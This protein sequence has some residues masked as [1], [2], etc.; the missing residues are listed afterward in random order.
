MRPGAGQ[1]DIGMPRRCFVACGRKPCIKGRVKN[2]PRHAFPLLR[3]VAGRSFVF[4]TAVAVALSARAASIDSLFHSPVLTEAA[5][6]Q[7]VLVLPDDSFLAHYNFGRL[8][9][10]DIGPLVKFKADGTLD[11]GFTMSGRYFHVLAVAPTSNGRLY[12]SAREINKVGS[13]Y[14][15]LRLNPDGSLDSSFNA[16]SGANGAIF[17]ITVQLDN[18]VLVGGTFTTFNGEDRPYLVRLTPDGSVENSFAK[19]SLDNFSGSGIYSN[20]I[21]Q[22]D[23][24]IVF[25]GQFVVVNGEDR[26]DVARLN[27][28]GTLDASFVPSGYSVAS[29]P[30]TIALQPDGKILIG[31]RFIVNGIFGTTRGPLMRLNAD[32]SL[33]QLFVVQTGASNQPTIQSIKLL[34]DGDIIGVGTRFFRFTAAGNIVAGY[35]DKNFSPSARDV[36]VQSDGKIL[37]AGMTTINNVAT[38]G[39]VRYNADG[40]GGT[41][42]SGQ[43]QREI[44]PRELA[45]RADGK[46]WLNGITFFDHIDGVARQGLARLKANGE[47]DSFDPQSLNVGAS[48]FALH[49]NDKILLRQSQGTIIRLNPDDTLDGSLPPSS[50]GFPEFVP[51]PQEQYIALNNFSAQAVLDDNVIKRLLPNGAFDQSFQFGVAFSQ[52]AATHTPPASRFWA[53]DNRPLAF[54]EDGRFLARYFDATGNYHLK[55]FN[56][57]GSLDPDFQG[58]DV[59]TL[60]QTVEQQNVSFN[61]NS[62]GIYDVTLAPGTPL[63]DAVLLPDGKIIVVGMFDHYNGAAAPAIVRLQSNGAIDATFRAGAGAQWTF[64]PVDATHI[65]RIDAI[66]RL[67]D[68]R[69]LIAGNF[70]AYDGAAAPGIARLHADGSRDH[71]FSSPVALADTYSTYPTY[72]FFPFFTPDFPASQL[73]TQ[74]DGSILLSG[75]YSQTGSDVVQSLFRLT[76]LTTTTPL[77]ISTRMR[78]ETG[79]NVLIGGFI[80]T[81]NAP[82]KVIVRAIGPTL[83]AAGVPRALANPTLELRGAGG[84][85]LAS[86][87]DWRAGQQI[88]IQNSGLAP[89]N[90]YESAIIT[91]LAPGQY[92]AIVAGKGGTTGAGLLEIYDLSPASD[93]ELANISTRGFV[94]TGNDVMIGGF[95]LG[96]SAGATRVLIRATGPSLTALGISGALQDPMLDLFDEN[97]AKLLTN[98]NWKDM[99]RDQI[100]A[101]GIPPS[102]DA[103]SAIVAHL[104]AGNYTAIVSGK[105]N[106]TGVALVE[107]YNVK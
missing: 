81:G 83:T 7:R 85:L 24:K 101:T 63:S 50:P 43:F 90:D 73:V 80:I 86:N 100:E 12:V 11:S 106:T 59:P 91:T 66:E 16:G 57:D 76:R 31:A 3:R 107:V 45:V 35:Q 27:S 77:N 23:G 26:L 75:N 36:D 30:R 14:R 60:T 56:S 8:G 4:I 21:V 40:T 52:V 37:V 18:N 51:A 61:N 105:S 28:N 68:G 46:I 15:L 97:G 34:A 64:T 98:D 39:L 93:S 65:P 6:P 49:P 54:Y 62:P 9:G 44:F 41:S 2:S 88:E 58:G 67:A 87:D 78:V 47:V 19:I 22:P 82:K 92:T 84:V 103:D 70:E 5:P 20:I 29:L 38:N 69:F 95:I 53:G 55:R 74:P 32:G 96:N 99:Q 10:T 48:D 104:T 33:H 13:N 1:R 79:E 25:A 72:F 89:Q 94:Q 17:S 42:I 71:T 102:N